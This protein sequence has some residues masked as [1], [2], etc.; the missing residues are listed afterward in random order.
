MAMSEKGSA[1][2]GLPAGATS[3]N[4][5]EFSK[6]E[7]DAIKVELEKMTKIVNLFVGKPIQKAVTGFNYVDK[8]GEAGVETQ[9]I[10]PAQ[11]TAK[12]SQ[13]TRDPDLKKSDRDLINRYYEGNPDVSAIAHL[14]K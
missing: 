9:K 11:I 10:T 13:L 3:G 5:G 6:S 1:P 2:A 14:L 12:L 7:V 8:N 4:G